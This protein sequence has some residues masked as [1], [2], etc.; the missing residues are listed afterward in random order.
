MK[1]NSVIIIGGGI[2]G[3]AAGS[4]LQMNGYDTHVLE[5]GR[6]CGGV[7]V[8]W[9]R[10][11]YVFDG[12][13]N[14]LP[15]S[16]DR[17][18]VHKVLREL[19]DFSE[20]EI[21]DLDEFMQIDHDGETFHVYT[22]AHQ[23]YR[24][25]VR[26]APEDQALAKQFTDAI[27]ALSA[28]DIPFDT[29]PELLNPC[30]ALKFVFQHS[31][32]IRFYA[33]WRKMT[34]KQYA[35]QYKNKRLRTML[36]QIFPHHEFFSVLSVMMALA[37]MH[38]RAAGYPRGGSAHFRDVIEKKYRDLGGT[39]T[40][41][42]KVTKIA[43]KDN[44]ATGVVCA[45]GSSYDAD[46]VV[47]ASDGTETIFRML[48]G[49]YVNK[50]L[51]KQYETFP[52]FPSLLQ[53]SLGVKKEYPDAPAKLV[54]PFSPPL[55][56]G[57]EN[58]KTML[59]RICNFDDCF[60]PKGKTAL[61]VHLRTHDYK[62]WTTLRE[63]DYEHYTREKQRIADAVAEV[64]D[65][66]FPGTRQNLETLD[67][68]TPATYIRYTNNWKGSYQGWAPTPSNIGLNIPKTLPG[69]KNFY[70]TGQWIATPGGLPRVIALGKH[71]TKIICRDDHKKFRLHP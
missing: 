52:V 21:I 60:S 15:G 43:V 58:A 32:V 14:W 38:A 65:R 28:M 68:A 6:E 20:M 41:H 62:Y 48:E 34:I 19:I 49:T 59:I 11:E 63:N 42:K 2:G 33:K 56:M 47:S 7:S 51:K 67:I 54:L 35:L 46:I 57:S 16:S 29:V 69:L 25:M 18:S 23:L 17:S 27:A 64:L 39:I 8:S 71:I 45:D 30:T 53:I 44:C 70:I 24:E 61:I 66:R 12:A 10:G 1:R 37:W 13:T 55:P 40:L 31:G 9:K 5:M 22:D 36:Q 4:Y 50:R 3:L 26:L